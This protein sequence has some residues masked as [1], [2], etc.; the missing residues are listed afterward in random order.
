MVISVTAVQ[1][2]L[3][4][5]RNLQLGGPVSFRAGEVL[6]TVESGFLAI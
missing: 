3:T 6:D 2:L 5:P 4:P 1:K